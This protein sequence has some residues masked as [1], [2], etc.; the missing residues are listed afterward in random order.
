M[1]TLHI[2]TKTKQ[3]AKQIADELFNRNYI[4]K[5]MVNDN[6]FLWEQHKNELIETKTTMLIVSSRATYCS[7]IADLI[8]QLFPNE[9]PLF[10]ASPIIHT[11]IIEGK[12]VFYKEEF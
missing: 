4:V 7:V 8:K 1:I 11:N 10:Y 2:I 9:E 5:A 6:I 12:S 3:Q